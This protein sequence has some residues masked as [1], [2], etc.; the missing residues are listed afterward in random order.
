M[1]FKPIPYKELQKEIAKSKSLQ[2]EVDRRKKM[3]YIGSDVANGPDSS[4]ETIFKKNEK[5][6]IEIVSVKK[7]RKNRINGTSDQ[8]NRS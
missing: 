3:F 6:E 8:Q 1:E 4:A 5:G 7:N 2:E